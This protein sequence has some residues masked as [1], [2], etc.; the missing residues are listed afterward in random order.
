MVMKHGM[1]MGHVTRNTY[2][3]MHTHAKETALTG[4]SLVRVA[5]V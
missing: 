2:A 4:E 3:A 5:G 1:D